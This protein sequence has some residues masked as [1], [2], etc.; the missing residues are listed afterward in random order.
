M[1]SKDKT[2]VGGVD[3]GF[4]TTLN[5]FIRQPLS[6]MDATDNADFAETSTSYVTKYTLAVSADVIGTYVYIAY[7]LTARGSSSAGGRDHTATSQITIDSVQVLERAVTG[8]GGAINIIPSESTRRICF[9]YEPDAGE[10]SA[11]FT[12]DIDLKTSGTDGVDEY[13]A[14]S[15]IEVWGA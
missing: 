10:K 11:G 5:S 9:K 15:G 4:T 12:I 2:W 8:L 7:D 1:V 13:F 6:N 3:T 14:V